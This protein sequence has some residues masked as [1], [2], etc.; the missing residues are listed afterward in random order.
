MFLA[1]VVFCFGLSLYV[2]M[3]YNNN[4]DFIVTIAAALEASC[5]IPNIVLFRKEKYAPDYFKTYISFVFLS[6]LSSALIR[7]EVVQIAI[8]W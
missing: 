6:S 7:Y 1:I 5:L 3:K 2:V 4:Y 8:R